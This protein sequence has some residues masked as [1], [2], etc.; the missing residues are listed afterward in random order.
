MPRI[1]LLAP[2]PSLSTTEQSAAVG[3]RKQQSAAVGSRKQQEAAGSSVLHPQCAGGQVGVLVLEFSIQSETS[4]VSVVGQER[5]DGE[6]FA[7]GGTGRNHVAEDR[8]WVR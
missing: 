4:L 7:E 8:R 5:C 2:S 3:S 6:D 1:S